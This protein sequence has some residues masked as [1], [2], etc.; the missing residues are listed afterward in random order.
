MIDSVAKWSDIQELVSHSPYVWM[1]RLYYVDDGVWLTDRLNVFERFWLE[2]T[3]Q[4]DPLYSFDTIV[5]T[6]YVMANDPELNFSNNESTVV[7]PV[8]HPVITAPG[9][10][11]LGSIGIGFVGRLRRRRII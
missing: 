7:L 10:I 5:N 2:I 11:V 1:P 3:A 6:A 4:V 9:A 8:T